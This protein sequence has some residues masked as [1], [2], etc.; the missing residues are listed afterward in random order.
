MPAQPLQ[1]KQ[2]SSEE[3][4]GRDGL[5]L[6]ACHFTASVASCCVSVVDR[7]GFLDLLLASAAPIFPGTF[8]AEAATLLESRDC[9]WVVFFFGALP[10]QY[11]GTD[12]SICTRWH[13]SATLLRFCEN[14]DED[15]DD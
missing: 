7:S 14:D 10:L 2:E 6:V 12:A 9:G 11:R 15:F 13:C 3:R 1:I 4:R 5:L 8:E